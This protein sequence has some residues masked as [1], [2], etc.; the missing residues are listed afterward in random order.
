M[1]HH[2]HSVLDTDLLLLLLLRWK[3]NNPEFVARVDKL[4]ER[5]AK[6]KEGSES[7]KNRTG[8]QNDAA[9]FTVQAK[10]AKRGSHFESKNDEKRI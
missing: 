5:I 7:W 10:L 9:Q 4:S 6:M 1:M 3:K 8:K 2:L